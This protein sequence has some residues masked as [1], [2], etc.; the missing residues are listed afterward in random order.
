VPE[1]SLP[2]GFE[3]R[4]Y[5]A[6]AMAA[7]DAGLTRGVYVWA[8][9]SGKDVTFM[10]QIAKMAH[11]RIGTYFH[12]LPSY[13]QGKKAVWDAIDDEGRRI[14]DHVFPR[15]LRASQKEDEMQIKFHCGSVYQVIGA[16]NFNTIVGANPVGLVMSEYALI[17]P[18]AWMF[19]RPILMQ[20]GG[21][22]AFIGTPRGYN[23]FH[24]Q[25]QLAKREDDWDWS[26]IDAVEAGYM[27][28]A[29]IEQEI[30]TGMP[31]EL[32]RQ[33]YLVDFSA[34]NVGAIL[35]ARIERAEKEGRISDAFALDPAGSG[36]VVS[37]DIGYRDA[38]SFWFW[39]AI[40]GGFQLLGYDEDTGLDAADW[41]ERL[42]AQPLPIAKVLL[43]HDA[44]AK[45]MSSRHSVLEQFLQAGFSCAIVPQTRIVDRVNAARSVI[46]RCSFARSACAKGLQMLRDWAFKY[47]E[48]RKT[49]SRE[50]DHNYASHGGDAFSYGCQSVMEFEQAPSPQ[51]RY[52]DIGHPAAYAFNLEQL[53]EDRA[54]ATGGRHF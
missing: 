36:V 18:R 7:F 54:V 44:K 5:Q 40:P 41:V 37:S 16:D 42:R 26:V 38:A 52:R 35:G 48:E 10:H 29:I 21:W 43:P 47:D 12:M 19:F 46:N 32:A 34:A 53:Y 1:L 2:N 25:L 51:D 31:E 27:T 39:Q 3:P 22:A 11:K 17:D 14:I 9:R 24:D 49:F 20:N 30:R 8:R 45:H 13:A 33:E 15:V 4:P 23:H 50:P 28:R 6:R